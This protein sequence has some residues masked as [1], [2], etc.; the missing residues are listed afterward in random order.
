MQFRYFIEQNVCYGGMEIEAK[1]LITHGEWEIHT[2]VYI[3]LFV[4]A[5][6]SKRY[7]PGDT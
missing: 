3:Q 1:N 7:V 6:L 4:S 5:N 2:F